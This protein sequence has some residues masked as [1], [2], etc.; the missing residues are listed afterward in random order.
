MSRQTGLRILSQCLNCALH[1]VVATNQ[2]ALRLEGD[3]I[4]TYLQVVIYIECYFR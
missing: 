4:S 3:I 1:N 2:A